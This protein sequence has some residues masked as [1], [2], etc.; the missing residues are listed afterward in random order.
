MNDFSTEA[1]NVAGNAQQANIETVGLESIN[2][3]SVSG[4][5]EQLLDIQKR[6]LDI[7]LDVPITLIFEVGRTSITIQELLALAPGSVVELKHV[8][9]DSLDIMV[10]DT[11]IAKGEII[12]MKEKFGV[13]FGEVVTLP[14][15]GEQ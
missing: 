1:D 2:N 15:S 4:Q 8:S 10:D 6:P 7:M 14:I 9:V 11:V 13:R 12:A 3:M 5:P